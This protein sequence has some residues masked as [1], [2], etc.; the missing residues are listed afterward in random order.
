MERKLLTVETKTVRWCSPPNEKK[1]QKTETIR[2]LKRCR[3]FLLFFRF[4]RKRIT[5]SYTGFTSRKLSPVKQGNGKF[6]LGIKKCFLE[7]CFDIGIDHLSVSDLGRHSRHLYI[8]ILLWEE[9]K[10]FILNPN[11]SK[12]R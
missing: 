11:G 1:K 5:T 6:N 7:Q 10:I 2:F 12:S 4:V 3:L 9:K 8:I